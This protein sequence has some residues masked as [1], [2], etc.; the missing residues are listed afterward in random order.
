MSTDDPVVSEAHPEY[1]YRDSLNRR[2]SRAEI[3]I[4]KLERRAKYL[5]EATGKSLSFH[6]LQNRINELQTGINK[7]NEV[8][9]VVTAMM[10]ICAIVLG[11]LGIVY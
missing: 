10:G 9:F 4:E 8:G 11:I 7:N 2:L 3:Q 6:V 1:D 5:M